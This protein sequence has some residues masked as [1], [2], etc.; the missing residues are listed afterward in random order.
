MGTDFWIHTKKTADERYFYVK[1]KVTKLNFLK[2]FWC[3]C[4]NSTPTND[5]PIIS[6]LMVVEFVSD[7]GDIE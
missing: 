4:T 5:K 6:D 3:S 1:I 2:I 7:S